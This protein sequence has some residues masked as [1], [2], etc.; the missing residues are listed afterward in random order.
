MRSSWR[1]SCARPA[2]MRCAA[3]A[4]RAR[5]LRHHRLDAAWRR[6]AAASSITRR[7]HAVDVAKA[8][9]ARRGTPR[10]RL[11]WP[12]SAAAGAVPPAR[13]AS[14]ASARHGKRCEVGLLELQRADL[15]SDRAARRPSRSAPGTPARARSACACRGCPAAPAPS[16]R[17][18]TPSSGS[19]F[20]GGSRTSICSAGGAEQPVR[21]DHFQALVHHGGGV[22]RDLAAHRP[23]SGACR[24][25]PA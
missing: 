8:D 19:R 9:A 7:D 25:R 3:A 4:A 11:R 24:L 6:R 21:L 23:S 18:T 15:R 5:V 13:S 20:A 10:P 1:H 16:R 2:T 12:R 14:N 22:D 17:R